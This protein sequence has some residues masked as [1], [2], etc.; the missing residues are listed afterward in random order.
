VSRRRRAQ[1]IGLVL[2]LLAIGADV[3]P[4]EFRDVLPAPMEEFWVEP[5]DLEQRDLFAGP[6]GLEHAP[7]P[8]EQ[9]TFVAPKTT[10][11]N[12]GMT[13]KD[14]RD[15]EWSVKQGNEAQPE[16]VVSR[17][18]SALG[19]RQPPVYYLPEFKLRSGRGYAMEPAGR[20]R[21]K[22]PQLK[23]VGDWKWKENPFVGTPPYQRLLVVLA[24]V[25]S[26]DL[27]DINNSLYEVEDGSPVK[28][29]WV[30]RDLGM[31]FGKLRRF[32]STRN[33]AKHYT[34]QPFILGVA[35]GYVIFKYPAKHRSLMERITPAELRETCTILARLSEQQ[36]YDAFRAG[37]YTRASAAPFIDRMQQKIRDGLAINDN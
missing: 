20:F 4:R 23:H 12:P 9:F 16:V 25:N 31:S 28:R 14:S 26:G 32:V 21:P 33:N 18:L 24:M 29:Y 27:K 34:E 35:D 5:T 3:E 30:V 2:A 7:N 36:W 17:L 15:R 11:T 19:Y 8:D 37:G 6:W 22:I 10:G 1:A 13:V